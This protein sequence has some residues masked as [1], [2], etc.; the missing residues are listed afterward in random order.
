MYGSL[1]GLHNAWISTPENEQPIALKKLGESYVYQGKLN[2]DKPHARCELVLHYDQQAIYINKYDEGC[3]QPWYTGDGIGPSEMK[4][5][6]RR[7]NPDI[8][9]SHL[10][11]VEESDNE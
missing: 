2:L 4:F 1:T 10:G 6:D 7:A 3:T 5:A 9:R 11:I 8:C